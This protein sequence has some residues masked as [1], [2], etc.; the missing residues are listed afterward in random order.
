MGEY[1]SQFISYLQERNLSPNTIK[2]YNDNLIEFWKFIGKSKCS[3]R[4]VKREGIKTFL[5]SLSEKNNQPI[6]RRAKL[7][8]IR[9]FFRYL[10]DE[11]VIKNNPTKNLPLPRVVIK[12][13]MFLQESEIRKLL[14]A[15]R[16][17]KRAEV[18]I[19]ILVETGFRL[20]ELTG[21][22]V[23]D[24]DMEAKTIK[25]RRKG[26]M[27]QIIPINSGLAK[28]IKVFVKNK[29]VSA[30]L[31]ANRTG[32]RMTQRRV[33]IMVQDY[34]K[35]AKV[36]RAGISVHSF[37]HSFC[38]RMLENKVNLKTIQLLCG[39][40]SISTTERYLHIANPE[41]RQG[42]KMAEIH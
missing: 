9:S 20:S 41:L 37:R 36:D 6:T 5:F 21:V 1:I 39:H 33:A 3:I 10:E 12:E 28:L 4:N 38:V 23:G 13:P 11:D 2:V 26:N 14:Q 42:M 30:P 29:E 16:K 35:K 8:T 32:G 17:D 15:V 31:I 24:I 18:A 40:R 25:I 7:T 34:L 27:E 19:R 22:S